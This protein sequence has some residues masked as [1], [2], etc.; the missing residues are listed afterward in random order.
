MS[1]DEEETS[2][3]MVEKIQAAVQAEVETVLAQMNPPASSAT[4]TIPRA[5]THNLSCIPPG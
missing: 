5:S 4:S 3:V 2:R 1:S